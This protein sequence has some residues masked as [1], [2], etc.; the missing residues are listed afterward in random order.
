MNIIISNKA[1]KQIQEIFKFISQDSVY[2]AEKTKE[3]IYKKINML[4]FMPYIGRKIPEY[5]R[6]DMR[7]I[8]YKSYR[9]MYKILEIKQ[10]IHIQIIHHGKQKFIS[11][12]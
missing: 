11:K 4:E 2:Y 5:N 9:I 6:A 10:E 8:I 7:E 1:H 3:E 12:I